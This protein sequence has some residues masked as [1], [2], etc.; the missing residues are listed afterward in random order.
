MGPFSKV[1]KKLE[2]HANKIANGED[3]T[4]ADESDSDD[5][6]STRQRPSTVEND[7]NFINRENPTRWEK[8]LVVLSGMVTQVSKVDPDGLDIVCFGGSTDPNEK[9]SIYRKVKNIKDI[10]RMVKTRLPSGPCYMGAAMDLVLQEAFQR[11]FKKRNCGVLVLTAGRPDDSNRLDKSLIDAGNVIAQNG[12]KESPLTITFVH[13]GDDPIA[14]EYMLHL[15]YN[16]RSTIKSKKTKEIVD[17][18]DTVKHTEIKEALKEIKGSSG[19]GTNGALIGAFAGAAMGVGGMYL[20][21]KHQ[22][23]KRTEGWNGDWLATYDGDEIATLKVKDDMKG[24]LII[25]GFPGGPTT[26]KYAET[27]F[28]F[29]ITYRDAIGNWVIRGDIE[30]EHTIYWTDGTKWTEIEP[31]GATWKHYA[32]AAGAGGAV[33]YLLGKKFF[34]KCNKKDQADY[35]IVVD[36]SAM[37][38]VK[39]APTEDSE[40]GFVGKVTEGFHNMSTGQKVAVGVTGATAVAGVATGVAVVNAMKTTNNKDEDTSRN[41]PAD[42]NIHSSQS[43]QMMGN[44]LS[45]TWRST[46]D[47]QEVAVLRIKDDLDGCLNILGF[48]GGNTVGTYT[49]SKDTVVSIEFIDPD[50]KWPIKSS[51]VKGLNNNT[52][53]WGDGTRWDQIG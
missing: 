19:S 22:A 45:G 29:N 40:I 9:P 10:E 47:G 41:A 33:G 8:A 52:I 49:K 4:F 15:D 2:R 38:A 18:V 6:E 24:N 32:G 53:V 44:G 20:T 34:K 25:T 43:S 35:V 16:C 1:I 13:V 48:L 5:D 39:D 7:A 42:T 30:D 3:L 50:G 31:K 21:N 17:I 23:K 11:G 26:G 37:M 12:Y 36:R 27:Q 46:F 51:E 14:E 28:G